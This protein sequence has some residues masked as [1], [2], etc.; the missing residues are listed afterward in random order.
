MVTPLGAIMVGVGPRGVAVG[1]RACQWRSPRINIDWRAAAR[2]QIPPLGEG[3][4][5]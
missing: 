2:V 1:L 5:L 4:N 3:D